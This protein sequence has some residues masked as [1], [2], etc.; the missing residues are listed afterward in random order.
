MAIATCGERGVAEACNLSSPS[1]F[2]AAAGS[3]VSRGTVA[4]IERGLERVRKQLTG[5]PPDKDECR[6][7]RVPAIAPDDAN[8]SD[9]G[10]GSDTGAA[11]IRAQGSPTHPR[12]RK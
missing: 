3:P 9:A 4:L 8:L 6:E 1:L 10:E 5:A 7:D 2:R 11:R 12:A